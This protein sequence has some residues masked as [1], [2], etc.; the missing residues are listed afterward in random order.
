MQDLYTYLD[1]RQYKPEVKRF[2]KSQA[3]KELVRQELL[4]RHKPTSEDIILAK[5]RGKIF[6]QTIDSLD[7]YSQ[8]RMQNVEIV[9]QTTLFE[10]M[11]ILGAIG[12]GIGELFRKTPKGRECEKKLGV[13]ISNII[14]KLENKKVKSSGKFAVASS[15]VIPASIGLGFATIAS[16]PFLVSVTTVEIQTPRIARFEYLK[17]NLSHVNDFAILTDEQKKLA[18]KNSEKVNITPFV[19]EYKQSNKTLLSSLNIFTPIKTFL[20][21]LAKRAYY[22]KDKNFTDKIFNE[23]KQK[24][25]VVKVDEKSLKAAQEDCEII[26]NIMQKVDFQSQ[27]YIERVLKTLDVIGLSLFAFGVLGA[28]ILEKGMDLLHI[29]NAKFRNISSIIASFIGVLLLNSELA[30]YRND[31]IRIA[32]HKEMKKM[33]QDPTNFLK[34]PEDTEN[35]AEKLPQVEL[36]KKSNWY[37]FM[38]G[39]LQ[40]RKDYNKYKKEQII[41][42]Q[43]IKLAARNIKLTKEQLEDAKLRQANI[44]KMVNNLDDHKKRY[45]ESFEIFAVL[46]SNPMGI[47]ATTF[48]SAFGWTLHKIKNAPSSKVPF[49]TVLG[50]V[51]GLLPAIAIELYTTIEIRSA[52]RVSYMKAQQKFNDEKY[53]LNFSTFNKKLLSDFP[54]FRMSFKN[55]SDNIPL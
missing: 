53:F 31:A 28:F 38:K 33:L 52:A 48:G 34:T 43:K 10:I 2:K 11:A 1:Y 29:K 20:D 8:T 15:I 3:Q 19:N 51:V 7:E 42:A 21:I 45:E 32:R 55:T 16:I 47:L 22:R 23:Q 54:F 39:F 17:N 30:E 41:D 24:M 37:S 25:K 14:N 5:K 9:T 6:Q 27:D 40:D 49:Y 4:K 26:K 13:K 36:P 50:A 18:V 46:L 12:S 35:I 44:F